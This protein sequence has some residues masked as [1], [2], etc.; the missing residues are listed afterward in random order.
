M[1]ET[2]GMVCVFDLQQITSGANRSTGAEEQAYTLNGAGQMAVAKSLSTSSRR[3]DPTAQTYV[4]DISPTIDAGYY[5]KRYNNQQMLD[6]NGDG[7]PVV[8]FEPRRTEAN[9]QDDLSPALNPGGGGFGAPGVAGTLRGNPH[10]N[11][12][13]VAEAKM[14]VYEHMGVRRLTPTECERL[15]GFP[16][17]WTDGQ[18]DTQ[19]YKQLGNAVAVPVAEWI[20]RRIMEVCK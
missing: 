4:A 6:Q 13:P 12:D 9:P 10:N 18:S 3:L 11:S 20:G 15:Q 8:G 2:E 19:R 14:H 7:Y 16:D 17:G 1:N 5:A